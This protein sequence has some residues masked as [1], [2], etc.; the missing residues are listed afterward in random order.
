MLMAAHAP[1]LWHGCRPALELARPAGRVFSR[2]ALFS[3]FSTV[4]RDDQAR[5]ERFSWFLGTAERPCHKTIA[6]SV[7]AGTTGSYEIARSKWNKGDNHE[8]RSDWRKWT[9]RVK[10][11]Y[12]V[13]R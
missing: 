4:A 10:A 7:L 5:C 13:A 3:R 8:N 1:G 9:Y 2:R 6:C 12:Q 11:G